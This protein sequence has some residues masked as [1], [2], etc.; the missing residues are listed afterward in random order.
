MPYRRPAK[1]VRT[2]SSRARNDLTKYQ[3]IIEKVFLSKYKK[4]ATEVVFD[5]EDI[6]KAARAL[7]PGP[8]EERR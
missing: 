6:P 7:E 1:V 2:G 8:A 4:G 5:R 3:R